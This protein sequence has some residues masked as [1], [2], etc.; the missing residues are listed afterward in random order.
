MSLPNKLSALEIKFNPD[1]DQSKTIQ[2]I[3]KI[4]GAKFEIKDRYQQEE[5]YFNVLK[6]EKWLMFALLSFAMILVAFN[7]VGAL[8][9]IVLDKK[10]DI[11]ILKSMGAE[12][13]QIRNIFLNNGILL[14][15]LGI[16]IGIA[17]SILLYII[18][19]KWGL[20]TMPEGSIIDIYPSSLRLGDFVIVSA[21]VMLIGLVATL[22]PARR[23]SKINALIQEG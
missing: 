22:G 10:K 16:I 7:M 2:A 17:L 20:V 5:T 11:S 15:S 21:T 3:K 4:I 13:Y 14:T 1:I 19:Q 8:W 23:A 9:V 6:M 12:D 18:H